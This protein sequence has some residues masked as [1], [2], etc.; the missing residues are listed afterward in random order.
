MATP[1]ITV[2]MVSRDGFSERFWEK[3][4]LRSKD[5]CWLWTAAVIKGSNRPVFSI[6]RC[7]FAYAYRVAYVMWYGVEIPPKTMVLH[8]CDNPRCVNPHHLSLGDQT[9]NMAQCAER[10]RW[11]NQY[12]CGHAYNNT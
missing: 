6:A 3:V 1:K 10:G 11:V 4:D 12:A 8:S 5:E 2:E 9:K 7:V